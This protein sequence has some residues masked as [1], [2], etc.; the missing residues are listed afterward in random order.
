M[1][2]S[3]TAKKCKSTFELG[4]TDFKKSELLIPL[5]N[6][7]NVYTIA[8]GGTVL[9]QGSWLNLYNWAQGKLIT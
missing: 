1:F 6:A 4:D 9:K 3:R 2:F 8:K 7:E 5:W